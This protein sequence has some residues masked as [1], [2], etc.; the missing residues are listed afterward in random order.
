M[1]FPILSTYFHRAEDDELG[2]WEESPADWSI[3][4]CQAAGTLGSHLALSAFGIST[5]NTGVIQDGLI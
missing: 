5:V 3:L 2:E 4:K 1:H